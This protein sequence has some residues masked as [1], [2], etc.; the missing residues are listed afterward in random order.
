MIGVKALI[1]YAE[2]KKR[3]QIDLLKI[4]VTGKLT[5]ARHRYNNKALKVSGKD[6]RTFDKE[7]RASLSSSLYIYKIDGRMTDC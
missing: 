3:S 4:K 1:Y 2:V 7:F 5:V 6:P